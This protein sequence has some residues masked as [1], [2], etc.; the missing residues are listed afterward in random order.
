MTQLIRLSQGFQ[1]PAI[2]EALPESSRLTFLK[3]F[4]AQIGNANT[5]RSYA[6]AA[7]EFLSWCELRGA[8]S[9]GAIRLR[10]VAN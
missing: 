4:T 1:L 7:V 9:L 2:V 3:F 10:E 5:R 8:L 6:K